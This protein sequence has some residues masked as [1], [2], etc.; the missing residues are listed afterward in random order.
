M[1]LTKRQ[2]EIIDIVKNN[3]PITGNDIALKLNIAKS[4]IRSDLAVLTLTGILDGRP[5]VGYIYS[6]LQFQPMLH[7][8]ISNKIVEEVMS[9][10]V[11]ISTETT[12]HDAITMLFMYDVG[13]IY[14]SEVD[15]K[16]LVGVISRKDLLRSMATG[17]SKDTAVAIIMTRMPNVVVATPDMPILEAGELIVNHQVDSLPV[18]KNGKDL[19][20][21]G[22]LSKTNL[23]Q[24][25]V[26]LS[27]MED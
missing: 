26:E 5:K 7:E 22:K 9:N 24:L 20:I 10:P 4:T 2:Q 23:V 12:I 14:I 27:T 3:E 1:D 25:F 13:S 18:V 16:K 11:I 21:V 15:T 17:L 19:E 6:G 8:V